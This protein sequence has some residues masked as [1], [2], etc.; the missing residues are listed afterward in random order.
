MTLHGVPGLL[1]LLAIG[2][3]VA[4]LGAPAWAKTPEER[5]REATTLAQKGDHLGALEIYRELA[6]SGHESGSLYWNWAQVAE[7]RGG[8]GEALWAL[9]RGR[10]VTP[11]DVVLRREIERL[12]QAAN[13]DRAEL[14]PVPLAGLSRFASR[15]LL[16]PLAIALLVVSL[17]AHAV[18]RVR[19]A[20]R[21]PVPVA[22][23]SAVLGAVAAGVV[24]LGGAATPTG[25]VLHHG[26]PLADAASPTA[27]VLVTLR[28]GEVVPVLEAS[29]A[30]LRVQD[31]SGS[32]GWVVA[33]EVGRL[34]VPP[35]S[36]SR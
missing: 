22:W 32:R 9:L 27:T 16:A 36:A 11:S 13:L 19:K 33:S 35:G 17:L 1:R 24:L 14:T 25:V 28:E 34:E 29:G 26:V 2:T 4:L 21:W 10:E 18:A 20:W 3:A 23:T 31:S 6:V 8:V 30:Y 7:A 15:Y 5:F 12:R